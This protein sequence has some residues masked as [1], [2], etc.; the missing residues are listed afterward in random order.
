MIEPENQSDTRQ[1]DSER[2]EN[3]GG[4]WQCNECEGYYD[5]ADILIAPNPF[6]PED[7]ISGC[8]FCKAVNSFQ[9]ACDVVGCER[10]AS[11]G[12]PT[13]QGYTWRCFD[14]RPTE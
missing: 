5:Q 3:R 13:P 2:R 6:D 1:W 7:T 8:A 12:S 4:R 10:L 14:H 9:R 11:N